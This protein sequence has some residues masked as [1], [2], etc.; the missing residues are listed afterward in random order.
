MSSASFKQ[1]FEGKNEQVARDGSNAF[2]QQTSTTSVRGN[3]PLK[4]NGSNLPPRQ[5]PDTAT[6]YTHG[7]HSYAQPPPAPPQ[8]QQ[9]PSYAPS[10][11]PTYQSNPN[12]YDPYNPNGGNAPS[13]FMTGGGYA[14]P[15][16]QQ[17]SYQSMYALGGP[18]PQQPPH[19]LPP[20]HP[21]QDLQYDSSPSAQ[22]GPGQ[23]GPGRAANGFLK[24]LKASPNG[25]GSPLSGGA[26]PTSGRRNKVKPS[27]PDFHEME[28][29][30][31][32][33][34][35]NARS[36]DRMP[37][38]VDHPHSGEYHEYSL[39][40]YK[41]LQRS[42]AKHRFGGLGADD[43]PDK[44][45]ARAKNRKI[46][47]YGNQVNAVNFAVMDQ[48]LG[49]DWHNRPIEKKLDAEAQLGLIKRQRALQYAEAVNPKPELSARRS[50][51]T[52]AK[53]PQP[54][55]NTNIDKELE[56]LEEKHRRDQ[57][58]IRRIKAQLNMLPPA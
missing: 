19:H 18:P 23:M 20:M 37:V 9:Q 1:R 26:S 43:N 15:A 53:T 16:P 49:D 10:Y 4:R 27:L 52:A 22:Q 34:R 11:A 33:R 58:A 46:F 45:A 38:L 50:Y 12:G 57:E 51:P 39:A 48:M 31:H 13:F 30:Y 8:Q 3:Q 29:V 7:S 47:E 6:N 2:A 35:A 44:Q 24:D 21:Q 54:T 5:N 32:G 55:S 36:V 28:V 14:A 56:S 25:M 42:F 41:K 17:P 40:E